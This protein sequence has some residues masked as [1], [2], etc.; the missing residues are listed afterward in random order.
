MPKKSKKGAAFASSFV[1]EAP[2]VGAGAAAGARR[3]GRVTVRFAH[4]A[5]LPLGFASEHRGACVAASLCAWG[6][7]GAG[8][9]RVNRGG[10]R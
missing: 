7:R 8:R 3:A 4:V 10:G 1:Y 6:T 5:G 2:A 9:A